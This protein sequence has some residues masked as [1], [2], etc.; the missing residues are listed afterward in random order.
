[1]RRRTNASSLKS[2][3]VGRLVSN[4]QHFEEGGEVGVFYYIYQ[5]GLIYSTL[6]QGQL[7]SCGEKYKV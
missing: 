3:A 2:F 5:L 7:R 1:M 6:V 4:C